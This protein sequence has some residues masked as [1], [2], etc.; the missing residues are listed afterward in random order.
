MFEEGPASANAENEPGNPQAP[1]VHIQRSGLVIILNNGNINLRHAKLPSVAT[2]PNKRRR[3]KYAT[4]SHPGISAPGIIQYC[5]LVVVEAHGCF[6]I[7]NQECLH[8]FQCLKQ[9]RRRNRKQK[10]RRN[11][12][13]KQFLS[14][15]TPLNDVTEV[16]SNHEPLRSQ[17]MSQDAASMSYLGE[18]P[19]ISTVN[20]AINCCESVMIVAGHE[21]INVQI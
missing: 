13:Q 4:F 1:A 18:T 17:P 19:K 21:T 10:R 16:P 6:S 2:Q 9:K 8:K 3:Q 11:R 15:S 7:Q 20:V 5:P 14:K 12:K